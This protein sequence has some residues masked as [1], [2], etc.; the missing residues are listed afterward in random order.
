MAAKKFVSAVNAKKAVPMTTT[1]KQA[2]NV[3]RTDAL[4]LVNRQTTVQHLIIV[5]LIIK[6]V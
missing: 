3:M 2:K 4:N 5:I 6:F 1:V